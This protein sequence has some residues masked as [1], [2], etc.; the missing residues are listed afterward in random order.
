MSAFENCAG[1]EYYRSLS[2]MNG[3]GRG[4]K[5]CHYLLDTGHRR[6]TVDGV[7]SSRD[8]K[9]RKKPDAF[10]IPAPQR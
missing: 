6:E 7:C 9:R 8:N 4:N 1:C 2:R 5:C 3:N 10:E